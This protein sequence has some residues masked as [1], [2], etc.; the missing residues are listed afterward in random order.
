MY[1]LL[2][3]GVTVVADISSNSDGAKYIWHFGKRVWVR[4]S[5]WAGVDYIEI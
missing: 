2:L 4:R 5:N 1:V 3:C